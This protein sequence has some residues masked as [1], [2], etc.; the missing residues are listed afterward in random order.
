MF[1]FSAYAGLKAFIS[2]LLRASETLANS[3]P[4]GVAQRIK[5]L[6]GTFGSEEPVGE[7]IAGH[8]MPASVY[9]EAMSSR[10]GI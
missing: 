5:I 9:A 1:R 8:A 3:L 7:R 6:K 4:N 10:S 2:P